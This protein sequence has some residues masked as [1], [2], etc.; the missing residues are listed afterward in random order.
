[1]EMSSLRKWE[2]Y[3]L[4]SL[5]DNNPTDNEL[6][7]KKRGFQNKFNIKYLGCPFH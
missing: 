1:M 2:V 3:R 6:S 5:M 4:R 7:N